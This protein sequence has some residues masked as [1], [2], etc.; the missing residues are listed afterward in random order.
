LFTE[1]GETR[2]GRPVFL[3]AGWLL[4]RVVFI[5]SLGSVDPGAASAPY[6]ESAEVGYILL[7]VVLLTT[8]VMVAFSLVLGS[9][10]QNRETLQA[11][12]APALLVFVVIAVNPV[13]KAFLW[14]SHTQMFVLLVPIVAIASTRWLLALPSSAP[15][16]VPVALLIGLGIGLGVL[17]YASAVV[18]AIATVT[19][20]LMR[21]H[22]AQAAALATGTALLPVAWVLGVRATQGSFYSV[23]TEKFR[24]FVWILDGLSDGTL[25]TKVRDN[26]DGLLRSFFEGQTLLALVIAIGLLLAVGFISR[27]RPTEPS[28]ELRNTA[29]A[30]AIVLV[31]YSLFL[32]AMGFYQTRLTWA[33][34]TTVI[35]ATSVLL[36]DARRRATATM[37]RILDASVLI[38]VLVWY[39]AWVAIPEPWF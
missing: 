39:V 15:I 9:H 33:L 11:Q 32:F 5:A 21:R 37:G 4:D 26:I 22:L 19:A 17:S 2:L 38:T 14:T 6:Y 12:W 18:I 23:E 27:V 36:A 29:I 25:V 8:A 28:P 30:T 35:V 24:Q 1:A 31:W 20:L 34:I 13:T 7:N 16:S 3:A 10:W